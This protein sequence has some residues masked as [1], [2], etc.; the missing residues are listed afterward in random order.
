MKS[1]YRVALKQKH[2]DF[3]SCSNSHSNHWNSIWNMVVPKKVKIFLWRAVKDL[4]PTTENL[5]KK[6]VVQE[7]TCQ[8]CRNQMES[9]DHAHLDCKITMK[10][11]QNSPFGK[12][13][14]REMYSYVI[15]IIQSLHQ[16]QRELSG[17]LVASLLW[18]IWNA[19]NKML[20]EGIN[21][22]LVRLVARAFSVANSI[23]RIRTPKLNSC[24]EKAT[25]K[26]SVV[27]ST[28]RGM[29]KN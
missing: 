26:T 22:D 13:V 24:A 15:N 16:Q 3:S 9:I 21:E 1:G 12:L 8:I 5:W 17:E 7:A 27:V 29:G 18:V 4:L 25:I 14:Q 23:K 2:S 6:N 19:R 10:V 28:R 20:F 11:W